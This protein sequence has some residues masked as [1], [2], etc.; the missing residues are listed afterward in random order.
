MHKSYLP[1]A[2]LAIGVSSASAAGTWLG[3][4][5]PDAGCTVVTCSPVGKPDDGPD[6]R[7]KME[8]VFELEGLK[9]PLTFNYN[10][11]GGGSA[12]ALAIHIAFGLRTNHGWDC[13]FDGPKVRI[14][15]WKDPKT[16]KLHPVKKITFTSE[17][18]PRESLPA[19][20]YPKKPVA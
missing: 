3:R 15:G 18:L 19:V 6:D 7:Y 12:E 8:G 2:L 4:L 1:L 11:G 16:G 9:K 20:K 10:L 14:R 17:D 13:Q 5:D